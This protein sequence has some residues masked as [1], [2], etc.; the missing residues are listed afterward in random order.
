M[1]PSSILSFYDIEPK[2]AK[3]LEKFVDHL[4]VSGL[5]ETDF[6][7]DF[8]LKF[9]SKF[10]LSQV[11][12]AKILIAS[13]NVFRFSPSFISLLGDSQDLPA[14]QPT[15]ETENRVSFNK[16]SLPPHDQD[17]NQER[18]IK[19]MNNIKRKIRLEDQCTNQLKSLSLNLKISEE[20]LLRKFLIDKSLLSVFNIDESWAIARLGSQHASKIDV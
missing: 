12:D 20:D 6:S 8:C 3:S 5:I 9:F 17:P 1:I 10:K 14:I 2:Q 7:M 19:I 13:G 11:I 4:L 16:P 15:L 18:D